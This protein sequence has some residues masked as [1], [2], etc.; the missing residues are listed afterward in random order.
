MSRVSVH[1]DETDPSNPKAVLV[2]NGQELTMSWREVDKLWGDVVWVKNAMSDVY[3]A[4]WASLADK[5]K[6]VGKCCKD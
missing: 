5:Y 2:V 1:V 3:R 6:G 4:H